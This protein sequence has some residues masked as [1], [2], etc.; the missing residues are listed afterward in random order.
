MKK[1]VSNDS[2]KRHAASEGDTRQREEPQR[3]VALLRVRLHREEKAAFWE[4]ANRARMTASA[5]A[6]RRLLGLKVPFEPHRAA[7][8]HLRQ[9]CVLVEA[10][11]EKSAGAYHADITTILA[12]QRAAIDCLGAAL[13]D[14]ETE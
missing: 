8:E 2:E 14:D 3:R 12:A 6:R 1:S 4:L 13:Q 9:A 10:L 7:V 11:A 5:L